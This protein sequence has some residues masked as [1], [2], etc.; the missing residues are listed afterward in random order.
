MDQEQ[1]PFKPPGEPADLAPISGTR[2][3]VGLSLGCLGSLTVGVLLWLGL[4]SLM[5][6]KDSG[7]WVWIVSFAGVWQLLYVVPLTRALAR[8]PRGAPFVPGL[9]VGA[10]LVFL[11]NSSCYFLLASMGDFH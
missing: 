1:Q 9:W 4:V 3:L 7:P 11:L 2:K 6:Q 8:T 10:G 5:A